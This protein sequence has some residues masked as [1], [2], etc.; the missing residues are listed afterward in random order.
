ML[1][2]NHTFNDNE[3]LSRIEKKSSKNIKYDETNKEEVLL[4]TDIWNR[5][6]KNN[7]E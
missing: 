2:L 3:I 1:K 7:K 5:L 6:K 4:S